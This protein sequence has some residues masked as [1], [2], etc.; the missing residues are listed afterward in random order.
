MLSLREELHGLQDFLKA[1][2]AAFQSSLGEWTLD[3]MTAESPT[4]C[5]RIMRGAMSPE[6]LMLTHNMRE[7]DIGT[8]YRVLHIFSK[9]FQD[10][11]Q[12]VTSQAT[13]R[14]HR[15]PPCSVTHP[16]TSASMSQGVTVQVRNVPGH[17]PPLQEQ[18]VRSAVR[19]VSSCCSQ[20]SPDLVLLPRGF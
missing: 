4:A 11:V 18:P 19:S 5:D 15:R 14:S 20:P 2:S 1:S 8:L 16:C 6:Q 17:G 12:R 7:E 13:V 10:L 3:W 9:G